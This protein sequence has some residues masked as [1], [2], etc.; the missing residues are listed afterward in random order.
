MSNALKIAN[1]VFEA[2]SRNE[3]HSRMPVEHRSGSTGRELFTH[4]EAFGRALAGMGPWL[5]VSS[6]ISSEEEKD[7]N[8]LL[9]LAQESIRHATDA[10]SPDFM[11]FTAGSQ[12]LVDTAFLALG[13]LRSWNS[14]WLT[15]DSAVK[16]SVIECMKSTR[17]IK[18]GFSNWLLFSAMVE[19]FL[20]R[21]DRDWDR[22]R[23]DYALRQH[24][25][26]YKGDAVYG[27]GPSFHWDYYNGFV[28]QP[29]LFELTRTI[30][31]FGDEWPGYTEKITARARR[32]AVV[33]ERM[34]SP[35]GT[36]P[37][38]GR[39]L[40]YR[41]GIFHHLGAMVLHGQIPACVSLPGI[42]C[43]MTAAMKR[44]FDAEGT[45]DRNDWLQ[46]GLCGHQPS[47]GEGY[48]S[49]GSLYLTLCGFLPL[50]LEE[51]DPFWSEPDADWS[52]R[53]IWKGEDM[54]CDHAIRD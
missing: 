17:G 18:P 8:R 20:S 28:I 53:R 52:A 41:F 39:S 54:P 9:C 38:M 24:E 46:I 27:D 23:I 4:L 49:T 47:I 25:Q 33:Q 51:S 2:L 36:V 30:K 50:G 43:A 26:W 45:F 19:A 14:L 11:N 31:N 42:R 40:A 29:M 32:Y 21:A 3:L 22:M 5:E 44:L 48:I 34:I 6:G 35:E 37:V 13:L 10:K 15:L 12:P 16:E 7:R 1:P